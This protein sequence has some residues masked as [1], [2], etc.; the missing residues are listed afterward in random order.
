MQKIIEKIAHK[1]SLF[2]CKYDGNI[3]NFDYYEY[4]ITG[5]EFFIIYCVIAIFFSLLLGYFP[6][7]FVII[8]CL[9]CLRSQSGGAHAKTTFWCCITTSIVYV[10]IGLSVYLN[11]Y[12][13]ILFILSLFGFTGLNQVPK[14]TE[15]ATQ[16]SEEKQRFFQISYIVRLFVV[17]ILNLLTI[18]LY[19]DN[20]DFCLFNKN[21]DFSKVSCCLSASVLMNRFSLSN[22]CFAILNKTGKN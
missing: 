10:I 4:A 15:T 11:K 20:Y 2:L 1:I 9:L 5:I 19:L 7:I 21:I 17:F 14:Y 16:H 13:L 8:P 18:I 12:Y 22:L 3:E 6:Y